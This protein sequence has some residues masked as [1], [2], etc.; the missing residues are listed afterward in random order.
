MPKLRRLSGSEVIAIL[1]GFGFM[2]YAQAGS[3]VKL[4]RISTQGQKQ[5]LTVPRHR[6]LD[7]GTLRAI[8]RQATQYISDEELR[9]YFFAD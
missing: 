3:H 2:V 6:E 8:F 7:T 1:E 9:P 4:R 5:T